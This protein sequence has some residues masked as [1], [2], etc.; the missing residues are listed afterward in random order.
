MAPETVPRMNGERQEWLI[1]TFAGRGK[2]T[3]PGRTPPGAILLPEDIERH[4]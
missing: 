4:F 3:E 1:Q 2:L